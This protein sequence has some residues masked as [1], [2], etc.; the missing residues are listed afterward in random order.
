MHIPVTR[1]G[2]NTLLIGTPILLAM[3]LAGLALTVASRSRTYEDFN[4]LMLFF[5]IPMLFMSGA[6]FPVLELPTWLRTAAM[7]NP[8]TY[9]VDL[10]KHLFI[11]GDAMGRWTPDFAVG[12]DLV[13]LA[14][15][16]VVTVTLSVLVFRLREA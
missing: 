2:W 16:T 5:S 9:G 3:G 14:V 1:D 6:H 15:F 13:V 7:I 4:A 10:L 8:V 11:A 12:L